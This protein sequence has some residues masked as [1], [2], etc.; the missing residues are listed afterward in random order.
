MHAVATY[1]GFRSVPLLLTSTPLAIRC[2]FVLKGCQCS[3]R[4]FTLVAQGPEQLFG[5]QY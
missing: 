1:L 3:R 4:V 5:K 2:T